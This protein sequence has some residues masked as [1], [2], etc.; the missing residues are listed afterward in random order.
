MTTASPE[1][2]NETQNLTDEQ[3]A[4]VRANVMDGVKSV[5][6]EFEEPWDEDSLA[7]ANAVADFVIEVMERLTI[8]QTWL[9][10]FMLASLIAAHEAREQAAEQDLAAATS[11]QVPS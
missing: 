6:E 10:N 8:G 9:L 11:E 2:S 7:D 3:K 4:A 1:P 5:L